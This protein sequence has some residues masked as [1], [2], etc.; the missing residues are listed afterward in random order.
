[1]PPKMDA[2]SLFFVFFFCTHRPHKVDV[3]KPRRR[4]LKKKK[5]KKKNHMGF[6]RKTKK[7]TK[8]KKEE[9]GAVVVLGG[10]K[11]EEEEKEKEEEKEAAVNPAARSRRGF[12]DENCV[13][14]T[15]EERETN[16][17]TKK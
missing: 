3:P 15:V 1:M 2:F 10:A 6:R 13:N 8:E 9:N 4:I 7:T 17:V 5:K 16:G 11:E 12:E 14:E